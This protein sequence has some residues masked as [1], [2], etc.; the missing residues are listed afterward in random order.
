MYC[1]LF[2]KIFECVYFGEL[3]PFIWILSFRLYMYLSVFGLF[4]LIFT[5][6]YLEM[7][8]QVSQKILHLFEIIIERPIQ[9]LQL[10]LFNLLLISI[11]LPII[12]SD[13]MI[14]YLFLYRRRLQRFQFLFF[15]SVAEFYERVLFSEDLHLFGFELLEIFT[16]YLLFEFLFLILDNILTSFSENRALVLRL[17]KRLMRYWIICNLNLN[18]AFVIVCNVSSLV[19]W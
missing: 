5:F 19:S 9:L 2:M 4:R 10:I 14:I 15:V 3:K 11:D 6:L 17:P 12:K 18:L 7:V 1:W 13:V 8:N 16:L